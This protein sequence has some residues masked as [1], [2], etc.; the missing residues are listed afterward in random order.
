MLR[1]LG[2][3]VVYDHLTQTLSTEG[4]GGPIATSLR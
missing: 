1:E 2:V 4:D 3:T